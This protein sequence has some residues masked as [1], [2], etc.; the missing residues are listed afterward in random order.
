M[1]IAQA[2]EL[3]LNE[4]LAWLGH[5][6]AK[7]EAGENWYFSPFRDE[8]SPSF[9]VS[10]NGK[11]WT[12]FGASPLSSQT[13]A[14]RTAQKFA[15]GSII[16]FALYYWQLSPDDRTTAL[17]HIRQTAGNP[18]YTSL[19]KAQT[20][21][22]TEEKGLILHSVSEFSQWLGQGRG[23]QFSPQA[24]YL[25]GRGLNPTICGE[26]VHTVKFSANK[27]PK[28]VWYGLGFRNDAGGYE[29]R[30]N[31]GTGEDFK[32]VVGGKD[33][34]Y[35]KRKNDSERLHIFEGFTDFLTALHLLPDT[36]KAKDEH[37]LILNSA[38][39][40]ERA[41]AVIKQND[42]KT[43]ILWTQNDKTGKQVEEYFLKMPDELPQVKNVGSMAY[44]YE[45]SEDLNA[46][47]KTQ[48]DTPKIN[49]DMLNFKSWHQLGTASDGIFNKPKPM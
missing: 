38:A 14:N 13:T 4:F 44:M 23:R 29:L 1:N 39:L 26:Y 21:Q 35:I 48:K 42:Y 20:T 10:A 18:T 41:K 24:Q 8:K 16:D 25:A 17:S 2:K 46:W 28:K 34:T 33:I 47:F 32:G 5:S 36:I 19:P 9:K 45:T 15:G 12:D 11:W 43:L 6:P 49:H 7:T 22:Q 30:A 3:N 27:T 37:F 31:F 40:I